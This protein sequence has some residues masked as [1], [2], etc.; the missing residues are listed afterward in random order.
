MTSHPPGKKKNPN[1]ARVSFCPRREGCYRD[2]PRFAPCG[3]DPPPTHTCAGR[4]Q[5]GDGFRL[6]RCFSLHPYCKRI[7]AAAGPGM[8]GPRNS[9]A[10][11]SCP[12]ISESPHLVWG[13]AGQGPWKLHTG[14]RTLT[15]HADGRPAHSKPALPCVSAEDPQK[16]APPR[17]RLQSES[18]ESRVWVWPFPKDSGVFCPRQQTGTCRLGRT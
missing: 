6:E 2:G 12:R 3:S 4:R 14:R 5:L 16:P 1:P 18:N 17:R 7:T 10:R 11:Q 13:N 9:T 15:H 8:G